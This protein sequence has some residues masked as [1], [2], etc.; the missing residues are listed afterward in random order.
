M[1]M[2]HGADASIIVPMAPTSTTLASLAR[3]R[4]HL[5]LATWLEQCAG[6][7][8]WQHACEAR[9]EDLLQ[10]RLVDEDLAASS[11]PR[12]ELHGG[13]VGEQG[14]SFLEIA[15]ADSSS[16]LG[17]MALPV[18]ASLVRLVERAMEP[19]NPAVHRLWP[20]SF[21]AGVWQMLLV[22]QRS[23]IPTELWLHML[24]FCGL[25]WFPV[26]E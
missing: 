22:G 15:K 18:S 2:L 13:A 10:E 24:S 17:R 21:R 20:P 16:R 3:A 9:R 8:I 6:W 11:A 26:A 14:W 25:G 7:T 12:L 4:Q 5:H 1:L 19:W 23:R